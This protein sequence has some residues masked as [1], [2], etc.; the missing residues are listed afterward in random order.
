[1]TVVQMHSR[2]PNLEP[3]V[4]KQEVAELLGKSPSWVDHNLVLREASRKIGV[5]R[6]WRLSAVERLIEEGK[7]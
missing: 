3:Y 4:T 7:L 6:R 5:T 1:M 2:R